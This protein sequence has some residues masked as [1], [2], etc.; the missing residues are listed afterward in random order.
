MRAS[1]P[2]PGSSSGRHA[3]QHLNTTYQF[4]MSLIISVKIFTPPSSLP[5]WDVLQYTSQPAIHYE[6]YNPDLSILTNLII[7][8]TRE[9]VHPAYTTLSEFFDVEF[10]A[11]GG[12]SVS[13]SSQK[14]ILCTFKNNEF[15]FT[16]T[17]KC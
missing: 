14:L 9:Q 15:T 17:W 2:T 16:D 13:N 6:N 7:S 3:I 8:I 11:Y 5:P 12:A 4:I 10:V 1:A